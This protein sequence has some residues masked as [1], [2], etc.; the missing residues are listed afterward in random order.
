[1]IRIFCPVL[2]NFKDAP[3]SQLFASN[4]FEEVAKMQLGEEVKVDYY[5]KKSMSPFC[6]FKINLLLLY[7][8]LKNRYDCVYY[9]IDP[10]DISLLAIFSCLGLI[11][12]PMYV[13]KYTVISR[14]KNLSFKGF[15][16][17]LYK[18]LVYNGFNKIFMLTDSHVAD[19]I[20]EGLVKAEKLQYLK[21]GEDLRFVDSLKKEKAPMFT[22][23]S[24]G[25]AYRDFKTLCEAFAMVKGAKLKIFS[26]RMWGFNKFQYA[27][28][29]DTIHDP[30]IEVVYTDNLKTEYNS[31]LAYL[32]SEMHQAHCSVS[33]CEEV[34][35]G[36]GYTQ[37]LDS[38]ACGC[39]ILATYNEASPINIGGAGIGLTAKA[40]DVEGVAKA[41]QRMV[42][43]K[44]MY[45][46]MSKKA[47]MMIEKE[48]NCEIVAKEVLKR[49]LGKVTGK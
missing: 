8:V 24:T 15:L 47:R 23:I 45:S 21:W 40:Y 20:N 16:T 35:F 27:D 26:R 25:K 31:I 32:F 43:D 9:T 33:I 28:Y 46:S 37:I 44:E 38:M 1:M 30:N 34:P 2:D 5:Y 12:V 6:T 18:R 14:S 48:Y 11:R 22:F 19:S 17:N 29:L 10:V 49:M 4:Y 36:V 39:S 3:G 7:K 13:W 41:M 42:D